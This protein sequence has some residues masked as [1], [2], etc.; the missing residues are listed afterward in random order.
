MKHKQIRKNFQVFGQNLGNLSPW[1]NANFSTIL[2]CHFC[3]PER[4][5]FYLQNHQTSYQGLFEWA[6]SSEEFSSF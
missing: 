1:E 4:L 6:T 3:S 2:E 5:L